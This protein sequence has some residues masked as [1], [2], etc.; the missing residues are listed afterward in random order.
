MTTATSHDTNEELAKVHAL[1]EALGI[2]LESQELMLV[3][4]LTSKNFESFKFLKNLPANV[5]QYKV[6]SDGVAPRC[7]EKDCSVD[8]LREIASRHEVATKTESGKWRKK[9]DLFAELRNK[10]FI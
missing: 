6:C 5:K 4:V 9:I 1:C 8:K 3:F 2:D 7:S 10:N